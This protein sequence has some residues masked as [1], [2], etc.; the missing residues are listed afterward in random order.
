MDY[1]RQ[2]IIGECRTKSLF[3]RS[4]HEK[5][6]W[7]R[8]L[9]DVSN[10]GAI[11]SLDYKVY[12]HLRLFRLLLQMENIRFDEDSWWS[13]LE[14]IDASAVPAGSALQLRH[15]ELMRTA[16]QRRWRCDVKD[17]S[18]STKREGRLCL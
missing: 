10:E 16:V 11:R 5:V 13:E 8:A 15:I 3:L 14:S 9:L 7:M 17:A 4:C 2:Q 18:A 6:H 1:E 12:H